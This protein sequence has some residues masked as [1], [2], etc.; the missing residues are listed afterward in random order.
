MTEDFYTDD[1]PPAIA[2]SDYDNDLKHLIAVCK[3]ITQHVPEN[4]FKFDSIN[5]L[6]KDLLNATDA[7]EAW[8]ENTDDPRENGWVDDKGR[9]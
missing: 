4:Y 8:Y 9:P 6:F 1:Y 2:E 7:V 5:N 3:K